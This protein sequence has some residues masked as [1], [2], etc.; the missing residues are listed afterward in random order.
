MARFRRGDKVWTIVKTK[1]VQ[2]TVHS[3]HPTG[4]T[5]FYIPKELADKDFQIHSWIF[6]EDCFASKEEL[7]NQL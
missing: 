2:F 4:E 3:V 1:A 7:I 5:F 6:E